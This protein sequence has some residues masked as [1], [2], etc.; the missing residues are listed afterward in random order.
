M[1]R[2]FGVLVLLLLIAG[3]VTAQVDCGG[4]LE[5]WQIQGSGEEANCVQ[6]RVRLEDN[7]VTA[8]DNQAS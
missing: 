8:V 2:W 6:Q 7:L 4:T 1:R 5:I 3:S